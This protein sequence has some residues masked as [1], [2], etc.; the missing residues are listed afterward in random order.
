[1]AWIENIYRE[2]NYVPLDAELYLFFK[3][4]QFQSLVKIFTGMKG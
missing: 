3:N 1:M 4:A 2:I